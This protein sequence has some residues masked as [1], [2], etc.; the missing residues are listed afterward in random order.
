MLC[1]AT[2]ID[3]RTFGGPWIPTRG[4][5]AAK[6][7]KGWGSRAAADDRRDVPVDH[8]PSGQLLVAY[9]GPPARVVPKWEQILIASHWSWVRTPR[10]SCQ[11]FSCSHGDIRRL[12]PFLR[13]PRRRY[14]N[15]PRSFG[16]FNRGGPSLL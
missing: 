2:G 11:S 4:S 6:A 14:L 13:K 10:L 15:P 8:L 1:Y 16:G 9:D 3:Q 12:R 5:F 7:L